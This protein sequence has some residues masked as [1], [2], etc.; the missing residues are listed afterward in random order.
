[1]CGSQIEK[2][3][4]N[5]YTDTKF[6]MYCLLVITIVLYVNV[7]CKMLLLHLRFRKNVVPVFMLLI[8]IKTLP[9]LYYLWSYVQILMEWGWELVQTTY[10]YFKFFFGMCCRSAL[11]TLHKSSGR[12]QDNHYFLGGINHD[13]VGFYERGVGSDQS[14]INEW[15]AMDSLESKRPPSPDSLTDKYSSL[16]FLFLGFYQCL[17]QYFYVV[18]CRKAGNIKCS[19]L[20]VICNLLNS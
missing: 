18:S 10:R 13:W 16:R 9:F 19:V 1:M 3:H 20:S 8:T 12:A 6:C 15:N 7:D 2:F 11:Q 14:C 4:V 5:S 17:I